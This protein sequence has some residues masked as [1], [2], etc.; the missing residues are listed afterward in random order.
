[1]SC[2]TPGHRDGESGHLCRV[3]AARLPQAVARAGAHLLRLESLQLGC[4]CHLLCWE[5]VFSLPPPLVDLLSPGLGWRVGSPSASSAECL[6]RR[7]RSQ[8][9]RRQTE[10]LFP[11]GPLERSLQQGL[12]A[13]RLSTACPSSRRTSSRLLLPLGSCC[14]SLPH[15]DEQANPCPAA[16]CQSCS[17]PLETCRPGCPDREGRCCS[18]R[19]QSLPVPGVAVGPPLQ[20]RLPTPP[21][22]PLLAVAALA[23]GASL[24]PTL[25][26][27]AR[28]PGGDGNAAAGRISLSSWRGFLR[29]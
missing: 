22:L 14:R 5:R 7:R 6:P 3:T 19:C 27:A 10:G 29:L 20:T 25:Q 23:S 16:G 13:G 2:A 26:T 17:H 21:I 8:Q 15:G 9:T 11:S 24:A 12:G 1:M 28:P 18:Q 4:C